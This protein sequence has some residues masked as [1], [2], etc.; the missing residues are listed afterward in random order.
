M[1]KVVYSGGIPATVSTGWTRDAGGVVRLTTITDQVGIGTAT[2]GA[3]I[4]LDVV[5][6]TRTQGR[7]IA[8]AFGTATPYT[9][10][11]GGSPD[12]FIGRDAT[13]GNKA[14][15]LIAAVTGRKVTIKN[16]AVLAVLNTVAVTPDGVQTIDGVAYPGG[17]L[18]TGTQSLTLVGLTGTG[19]YVK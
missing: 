14:V 12:E 13:L 11:S 4:A 16:T 1:P 9:M 7:I 17:L 3:G 2:P 15:L 5:G 18:L 19:W 6:T 8:V 10:D